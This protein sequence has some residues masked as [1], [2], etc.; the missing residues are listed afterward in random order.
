MNV[1]FNGRPVRSPWARGAIKL[2]FFVL[3][4]FLFLFLFAML[5]VMLVLHPLFAV[6]GLKGTIRNEGRG[7]VSLVLDHNSFKRKGSRD[8]EQGVIG[9]LVGAAIF[10]GFLY[11]LVWWLF[12]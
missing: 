3:F 9:K 8:T 1:T 7:Q 2:M 5:P 6:F 11:L 12:L 4:P 10:L